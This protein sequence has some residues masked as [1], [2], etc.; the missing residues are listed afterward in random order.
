MHTDVCEG[1]HIGETVSRILVMII[2]INAAAA[3]DN[4]CKQQW[5]N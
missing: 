5:Q 3:A 4:A 2:V 1:V